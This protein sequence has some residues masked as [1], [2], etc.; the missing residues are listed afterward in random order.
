MAS[1]ESSDSDVIFLKEFKVVYTGPFPVSKKHG[2]DLCKC[3]EEEAKPVNP[4]STSTQGNTI[5]FSL[6]LNL[7]NQTY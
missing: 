2:K 4:P 1:K 3:R 7:N 6:N 5:Y